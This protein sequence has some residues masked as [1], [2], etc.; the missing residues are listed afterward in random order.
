MSL[1][2]YYSRLIH[3]RRITTPTHD[4]AAKDLD[5][6]RRTQLLLGMRW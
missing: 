4:E 6:F 1:E 3:G 5:R 2:R